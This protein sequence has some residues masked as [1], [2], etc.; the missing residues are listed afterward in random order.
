[1]KGR[2]TSENIN[3]LLSSSLA[4]H[5]GLGLYESF[6]FLPSLTNVAD[7]PTRDRELR[8]PCREEPE[9]FADAVTGDFGKLD[10][11]LAEL[12]YDPAEV[13]GL[14]F[15]S[16]FSRSSAAV[17]RHLSRLR[18][19]QKPSRLARFD[20]S[21]GSSVKNNQ[22]DGSC[23]QVNVDAKCFKPADAGS[24]VSH[25]SP[26]VSPQKDETRE[27]KEEPGGPK[28]SSTRGK[29]SDEETGP[30]Q[31]V[32]SPVRRR[33]APPAGESSTEQVRFIGSSAKPGSKGSQRR[34]RVLE[35]EA[36][37]ELS[38]ES[39]S[40]L[41]AL[42]AAQFFG[43]DGRRMLGAFSC[44]RRGILDLYSGAAGV[45]RALSKKYRVWVLCFDFS[46]HPQEDLLDKKVQ[47]SIK[48]MIKSGCFVAAGLAPD[49]SSFSRA[50]TPAVRDREWPEGRPD[51]SSNMQ[52]KVEIGNDHGNFSLD[53]L[54]LAILC[55]IHYKVDRS[56]TNSVNPVMIVTLT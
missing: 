1:M 48:R 2:S 26:L 56:V 35:N 9:W 19:V 50:V 42:P 12:G 28:E 6:G 31:A 16:A 37:P 40:L 22:V 7:D 54:L 29:K 39:L 20:D 18:E 30:K 43:P 38:E 15:C 33:V 34:S 46:H 51:I 53:I 21:V 52:R 25:V 5:L 45:A 36:L 4:V 27:Q 8:P 13:A 23:G 10:R 55:R 24:V 41:R 49:C 14:P 11:W 3:K 17:K 32:V 47:G 44:K